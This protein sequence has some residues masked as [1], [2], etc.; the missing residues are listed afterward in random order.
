MSDISKSCWNLT[1]SPNLFLVL[2]KML[3]MTNHFAYY[4]QEKNIPCNNF[5]VFWEQRYDQA[6]T[7][8]DSMLEVFLL[9]LLTNI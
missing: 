9:L 4:K 7:T 3:V 8:E 5:I 1:A 2:K 6:V